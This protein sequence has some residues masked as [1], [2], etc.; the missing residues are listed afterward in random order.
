METKGG[1]H[2]KRSRQTGDQNKDFLKNNN[3]QRELSAEQRKEIFL[4]LCLIRCGSISSF[5]L[6]GVRRTTFYIFYNQFVMRG[7]A[8][9]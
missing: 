5:I 2:C 7:L 9:I 8:F 4:D 6:W 1:K 3:L